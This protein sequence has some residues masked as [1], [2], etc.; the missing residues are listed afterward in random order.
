MRS[1][2]SAL[3]IAV[4]STAV[5]AQTT[6]QVHPGRG[7][8]PH[9]KT[10][11]TVDGAKISIT[12]G[13]PSLKG[14]PEATLM[15]PG[16]PWR[17]GADEATQITSDKALRFGS[18]EMPAGTFTIN[19]QP[20]DWQFILGNLES[21][22]QWGIPY[23]PALERGKAPMKHTTSAQPVEQL[24]YSITDTPQ[25]GTLTM[26]WGTASAAIDFTVVP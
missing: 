15:P 8:S 7:G 5:L 23:K 26:Q 20:G 12:Y 4:F 21:P 18:L 25:G 2:L 16:Q 14:R 17:A 6:T 3:A 1:V 24:T 9:V 11:W 13:R 10:E 22:T 19:I